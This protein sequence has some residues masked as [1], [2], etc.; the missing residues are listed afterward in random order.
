[1]PCSTTGA[2]SL[3]GRLACLFE[4]AAETTFYVIAVYYGSVNVKDTRYTL[5]VMLLADLVCII[6]AVIVA[7]A[8]F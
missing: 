4:G 1:M 3:T 7:V 8:W 6:T 2:D 5:S